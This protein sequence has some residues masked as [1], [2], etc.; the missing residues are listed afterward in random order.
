MYCMKKHLL[1]HII[2]L[3]DGDTI[4][5]INALTEPPNLEF[6]ATLVEINKV[7]YH[8]CRVRIED[9]F[10]VLNEGGKKY[11]LAETTPKMCDGLMIKTMEFGA[12]KPAR[13]DIK[14]YEEDELCTITVGRTKY[15]FKLR[16]TKKKI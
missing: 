14:I 9:G 15:V 5:K 6:D 1:S 12:N 10:F 7:K 13:Y 8:K 11:Y 3:T 16:G 4:N 2:D